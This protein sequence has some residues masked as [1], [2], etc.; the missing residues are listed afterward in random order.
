MED[1]DSGPCEVFI[2]EDHAVAQAGLEFLLGRVPGFVIVGRARDGETALEEAARLEPDLLLLDLLLP[3]KTGLVVLET[4]AGWQRRPRVL[5]MSGQASGLDFKRAAELGADGLVSKDDE[6]EHLI[7]A[8]QSV[9]RGE[10]FRS[11]VVRGLL[12]PLE[13]HAAPGSDGALPLT[14]REREVLVLVA[15]GHANAVIGEK[16]GISPA[17]AKKHRENIHRKLGI[18]TAVEATRIAARLG[19]SKL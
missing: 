19:L 6:A 10:P 9:R 17:T 15:E 12:E 14:P 2:A 3:K 4:I 1:V 11:P 7:A 18:S 8:L 16:L 13:G 5:V